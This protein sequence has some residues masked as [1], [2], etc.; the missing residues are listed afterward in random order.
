MSVSDKIQAMK[1]AVSDDSVTFYFLPSARLKDFILQNTHPI[2]KELPQELKVVFLENKGIAIAN[3]M[4][5]T[6]IDGTIDANNKF[7]L[8]NGEIRVID[9]NDIRL[10]GFDLNQK[11]A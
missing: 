1:N 3:D 9:N 5:L 7:I 11:G 10:S 6:F 8:D 4:V 2:V